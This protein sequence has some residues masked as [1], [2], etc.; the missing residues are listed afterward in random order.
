MTIATIELSQQ[1]S[2]QQAFKQNR[3]VALLAPAKMIQKENGIAQAELS[4]KNTAGTLRSVKLSATQNDIKDVTYEKPKEIKLQLMVLV[5]ERFLGRQLDISDFSFHTAK[6]DEMSSYANSANNA[7]STESFEQVNIDGQLFKQ[8]D[9]LSVEEWHSHE[10]HLNY[11]VQGTFNI[12]DKELSLNYNFSLSNKRV[13]Y[14]KIEISA[15]TLKDPILVQFGTQ[16]LGEIKGQKDFAINQDNILDNLPIFSGDIGYLVYDKNDNQQADNGS[17]LFGPQTGQGFG[18]LALLD[19]N[20]NGFIDAGDQKF[21]QLYIWQP[22]NESEQAEK[23]MSLNE[24]KIEVIS[25]SA[26]NTPFDFYDQQG[27]L[28]AQLRQ[29]SFAI[30][31]DGYARGV[32]QVDVRI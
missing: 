5:L 12:N 31:E 13:S 20:E 16:G 1:Q 23:W 8:D 28:Q 22:N 6:N 3:K 2:Y 14:S 32:H 17:E 25:L 9:L 18:E 29:S 19:S 27:Q 30:S 24:A 11:Q 10:Q 26:I 4:L 21:E 7:F 15:A